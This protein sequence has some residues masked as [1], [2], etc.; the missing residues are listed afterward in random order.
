[1]DQM[2]YMYENPDEANA[3]ISLI[4]DFSKCVDCILHDILMNKIFISRV[5]GMTLKRFH[6]YL[7]SRKHYV[8]VNNCSSSIK[9]ITHRVPQGT[10]LGPLLFLI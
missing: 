7:S 5:R 9:L 2:K 10:T 6:S 1:M 8:S 3:V 4:L